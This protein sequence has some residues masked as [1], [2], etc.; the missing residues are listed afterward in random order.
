M[1]IPYYNT[2]FENLFYLILFIVQDLYIL[3]IS[4]LL[5]RWKNYWKH[6]EKKTIFNH[7]FYFIKILLKNNK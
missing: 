1:L 5:K 6:W 7:D 3:E 4:K 2:T